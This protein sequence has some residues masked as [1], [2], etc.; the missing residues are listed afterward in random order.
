MTLNNKNIDHISPL[1]NK[2]LF[3]TA[4]RPK[5]TTL[6]DPDIDFTKFNITLLEEGLE[7]TIQEIKQTS[8]SLN[9]EVKEIK[10]IFKDLSELLQKK[11]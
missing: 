3:Q 8:N 2:P 11:I 9:K 1:N 5:D 4:L 7:K 6:Y 10:K